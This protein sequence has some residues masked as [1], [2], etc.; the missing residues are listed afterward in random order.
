MRIGD[1]ERQAALTALGEH[2]A[3]GR[4]DVD[5]YGERTAK[6]TGCRTRGELLE[7]FADLPEPKPSFGSLVAAP[8][9]EPAQ[10]DRP[11]PVA[12]RKERPAPMRLAAMAVTASWI[13]AV[14]L[15]FTQGYL[16]VFLA[17]LALSALFGAWWGKDWDRHD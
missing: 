7:L 4:L 8:S 1:S 6:V 3:A 10:P 13:A 5:E 11:A 2:F 14:V 16:L 17:P 9:G 12:R 15:F